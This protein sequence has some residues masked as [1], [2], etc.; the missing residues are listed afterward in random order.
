MCAAASGAVN[1]QAGLRL[2][3]PRVPAALP[4]TGFVQAGVIAGTQCEGCRPHPLGAAC[5]GSRLDH[6]TLNRLPGRFPDPRQGHT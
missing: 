3:T 5:R 2:A 6:R 1:L 4:T